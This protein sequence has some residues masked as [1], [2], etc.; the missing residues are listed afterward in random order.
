MVNY[1]GN[2][3]TAEQV[4]YFPKK[5]TYAADFV[6]ITL[7][8]YYDLYKAPAYSIV[9]NQTIDLHYNESHLQLRYLA[10]SNSSAILLLMGTMSCFPGTPT[11]YEI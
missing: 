4:L 9:L 1:I 10:N 8:T 7:F 2:N 3:R 11:L 6:P 5:Y